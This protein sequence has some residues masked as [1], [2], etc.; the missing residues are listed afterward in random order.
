[1]ELATLNAQ[2]SLYDN[3]PTALM[4]LKD[5]A[6]QIGVSY[7]RLRG[8]ADRKEI[9]QYCGAVDQPG[10]KGRRWP[11]P[12][13]KIFAAIIEAQDAHLVTPQTAAA[14]I[15]R[16][17]ADGNAGLQHSNNGPMIVGEQAQ[18]LAILSTIRDLLQ[19]RTAPPEDS[20]INAAEA[21]R[22]LCCSPGRVR[23]HVRPVLRGRWRRSD[24][25]RYIA[26]L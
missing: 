16:R 25:M 21:G 9:Q 18:Q 6:E 5:I 1:M 26:Q 22:I 20:L 7:G 10:V 13:A 2:L 15:A 11:P 19:E 14:W 4:S 8:F 23:H 24:I 12:S 17:S 3:A